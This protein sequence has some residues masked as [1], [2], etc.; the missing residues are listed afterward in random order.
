MCIFCLIDGEEQIKCYPG[1]KRFSSLNV[2]KYYSCEEGEFAILKTCPDNQLYWPQKEICYQPDEGVSSKKDA[3]VRRDASGS[4]NDKGRHATIIQRK[5]LRSD[6]SLGEFYDAKKDQFLSG[7]SLWS[8]EELEKHRKRKFARPSTNYQFDSG[9]TEDNRMSLM[10]I[11]ASLKLSYMGEA[12]T[13]VYLKI[14]FL[15]GSIENEIES[16]DFPQDNVR[17]YSQL[18]LKASL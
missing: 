14:P 10:D 15:F 16:N 8:M 18:S 17:K 2:R 6:V 4:G 5:L 9:K 3:R 13:I 7:V 11:D 12:L 1:I